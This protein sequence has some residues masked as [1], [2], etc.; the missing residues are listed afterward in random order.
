MGASRA[1]SSVSKGRL[2]SDSATLSFTFFLDP[3]EQ[4]RAGQAVA[5]RLRFAW[6]RRWGWA[7]IF[8]LPLV[9]VL[10]G[11]V[12]LT[13]LWP[14][15]VIL[16]LIGAF[17][18]LTP[19]ILRRQVRRAI[20]QT[21]SLREPQTYEFTDAGV[22]MTN[23]LAAAELRWGAVIEAAETEEFVLLYYSPKCAYYVPKRIIGPRLDELRAYLH[24]RLAARASG[25]PQDGGASR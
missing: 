9:L 4:V 20:A 22:R 6:F 24:A 3:A 7:L 18:A 2:T 12:P 23:P 14:Y 17:F 10:T 5:N 1:S 8:A 19:A 21:P 16:V 11:D 25:V 13:S 15:G